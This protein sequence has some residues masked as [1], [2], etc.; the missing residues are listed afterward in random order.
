MPP[1]IELIEISKAF[2]GTQA[3][4]R[5]SVSVNTGQV[6]GLLGENGAGKST[7]VNILAG[8]Y[9]MDA[10]EI[11]VDG[12]RVEVG[13]I[14]DSLKM[15]IAVIQQEL[16]LVPNLS[17]AENIFLGHLPERAPY[18]VDWRLMQ[19]R[20]EEVLAEI[21][22]R[23]SPRTPVRLLTPAN[24]QLV[25]IARALS[26]GARLIVMDEPTSA[27]G[28]EE[29]EHLF[30]LIRRLRDQGTAFIYI[31][32]RLMEALSL[33]DCIM[34]LR[35]GHNVGFLEGVCG[36]TPE[37]LIQLMVGRP[38]QQDRGPEA[39]FR[40]PA[41]V[42]PVLETIALSLPGAFQGIS[43]RLFAGEVLGAAGLLGSG[44]TEIA[45]AI[46]GA[47]PAVSGEIRLNGKPV[48][49]RSPAE[50]F[51]LGIGMVPEERRRDGLILGRSV[52]DNLT[53][54]WLAQ[55]GAARPVSTREQLGIAQP[56]KDQ[57]RI[58]V[59]RWSS[60]VRLLSGG[61]QQKVVIGK[62]LAISPKVLILDEPTRGID[63]GTKPEILR[64]IRKIAAGGTAVLLISSDLSEILSISDRILTLYEGRITG[65][66]SREEATP[67]R[68][69]ALCH[70]LT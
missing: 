67:E 53:L 24:R 33:C 54:P 45:R 17:V 57:L 18:V 51:R 69:S 23:F 25:Q 64:L 55:R 58:R 59:A 9:S 43:F 49:V 70:G 62:W 4:D 2:P 20:A 7:L 5:V 13:G 39:A 38:V 63:V 28:P 29:A 50:A 65:D 32:H 52:A 56:L 34:V 15:G 6:L 8:A 19:R 27:L 36:V 35:D 46:F 3:L 41:D 14:A 40:P 11:R 44:R 48:V 42:Q 16:L 66:L 1:L 21:G 37:Q 47:N 10:G 61:N 31:S 68:I 22:A 30:A 60:P 26:R 12:E